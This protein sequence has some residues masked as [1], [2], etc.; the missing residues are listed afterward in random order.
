MWTLGFKA[1]NGLYSV[2]TSSNGNTGKL[3]I[4][5]TP[6]YSQAQE[7]RSQHVAGLT[8]PQGNTLAQVHITA[9]KMS[10]SNLNL[11]GRQLWG[12]DIYTD[13]SDLVAVLMH[14]GFYTVFSVL[15]P[16]SVVEVRWAW[17]SSA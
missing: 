13:D 3:F 16:P 1:L 11:R 17:T 4:P 14:T 6:Q 8:S 12:S 10:S 15:P 5:A 2:T 9:S 7:H